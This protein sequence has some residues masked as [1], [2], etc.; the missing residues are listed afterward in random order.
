M[1]PVILAG[2]VGS[3]LWPL[4][5]ALYPKQF[6]A[7]TDSSKSLFQLTAER[8]SSLEG[9][10]E[11]L[12]VCNEQHRFMVAEQLREQ[13]MQAA[14]IVLE[15]EARNTAPAVVLAALELA[16]RSDGDPVMM[17][18]PA[19]HL[20]RDMAGFER[21]VRLAVKAAESG[22][23]V[24]LGVRPSRADVSYGY[25]R[26]V[27]PPENGQVV[28]V[29]EFIE[30]PRL[31]AAQ[32]FVA[33]EQYFWNSGIFLFRVSVLLEEMERHA[34]DIL[35]ACRAAIAGRQH[36]GQFTRVDSTAFARA[37][38]LSLDYAVM[39]H[40]RRAAML[41]LGSD[42]SD[43]GGW[44]A[45]WE[46]NDG[47]DDQGNVVRG[48]ALLQDVQ[49]SY[50]RSESRLVS[51]VG[52]RDM[53]IV[54]TADAVL[55]APKAHVHDVKQ[56]VQRLQDGAREEARMHKRVYRPW[57]SYESLV[58]DTGFQVKRLRVKPGG[59]LSLQLHHHRA[60]HWTVVRGTAYVTVGDRQFELTHDQSTYIP[61]GTK[62]RLENRGDTPLEVVEVQ[63][64]SYLGE[65]DIVRFDDQYGRI[66]G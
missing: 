43:V 66:E 56:C 32:R 38:G 61:L 16:A 45:L 34:P 53:V 20:I 33:S 48:D 65:D 7:L 58:Q 1:I 27:Q 31:E 40:T 25:I 55:V 47:H 57:G 15:P 8:V 22:R 37:P 11:P 3:R 50:V 5:R 36:D 9:S 26:T 12:V 23:L 21:T 39:E 29:S 63:T 54:E 44:S 18:L 2:G 41:P 4:S 24:T 10:T 64:G 49:G 14:E 46:V 60:E 62:H 13:G 17:V 30:K 19:D 6:L 52:L 51:A 35:A 28:E 42:W 59:K